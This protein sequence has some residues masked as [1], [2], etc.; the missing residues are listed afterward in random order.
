[1]F[2]RDERRFA[3]FFCAQQEVA[4]LERDGMTQEYFSTLRNWLLHQDGYAIVAE[5]LHTVAIPNEWNPAELCGRAPTTT[6]QG[7]A[8]FQ[9]MSLELQHIET[10][11]AEAQAGFRDGWISTIRIRDLFEARRVS[12]TPRQFSRYAK[13]L[14][15][16][17]HPA[18]TK[19][20]AGRTITEEAGRP[21]LYV[22]QNH[23]A[24]NEHDA[25]R[26]VDLYCKAQGYTTK[27]PLE[28]L[29]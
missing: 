12:V 26:V 29:A 3:A 24:L 20:R 22:R 5:Y 13:T 23:I 14:G 8:I 4:D 16:V 17:R 18:L 27:L 19:G 9:S 1:V 28:A 6:S 11:I 21:K 2:S 10:A 7:E 15:Y 25:N